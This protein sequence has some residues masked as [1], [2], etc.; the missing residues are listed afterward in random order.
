MKFRLTRITSLFFLLILFVPYC[1]FAETKT[2]IKEYTYQASEDDSRNSSRVTALR[3]VKRLLLEELGTYLESITEVKNFQLTKDQINSLTAGIV[4]TEIVDEKWNGEK[5]W[6]KTKIVADENDVIK[7]IDNLRKDRD[8]SR[9]LE[10]TKKRA[11]AILEENKKLREE[12]ALA[13]GN[14]KQQV[15]RRY[16]KSIK[17]LSAFEWLESGYKNHM[18]GDFNAAIAD[19]TKAIE[20]NPKF[21]LAYNN[22]GM[23]YHALGKYNEALAEYNKSTELNPK[24]ASPYNSRG[25]TYHILGKY[26]EALAEYNKSIE[27]NPQY[28]DAYLNRGMAYHALGRYN[29]AL[30]EYNKS[31]EL[32]PQN[33]YAYK[34]RGMAYHALGKYNEE[35]VE[36]NKAKQLELK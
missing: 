15:Q 24:D 26:K 1:A 20:L 32:N 35:R 4:R 28:A 34:C 17:E 27:L 12:L 5:Y 19:Y 16:D 6:I 18:Q 7:S 11:D 29:E 30:V 14:A 36:Y 23:A 21:D 13:K 25:I 8:K 10:D 33:A 9:E 31:I 22:R 2:F 3:E